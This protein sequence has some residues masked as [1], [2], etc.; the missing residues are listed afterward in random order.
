M[1]IGY[2]RVSTDDQSLDS[3]IDD[4]KKE[5]C[6]D[7]YF[8]KVSGAKSDRPELTKALSYLRP[9]DTLVVWKLDRLGRTLKQLIEL[10]S[11]FKEKGIHFKSIKDAIDTSSATGTFFFH[12]MGAFAELERAMIIERTRA[13][14]SAAR[15]RGRFGGRPEIHKESKKEIAYKMY[16]ENE[17]TVAEIADDLE[18]S[19]MTV[20]RYI[21]KKKHV[22]V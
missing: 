5:G 7:I 14:L 19:R 6:E 10:V 11:D 2:A 3:Q 8:E 9:G 21:E 22:S 18:M 1:K 12:V 13:G 16:M 20:Y 17:K 15:S 4:L